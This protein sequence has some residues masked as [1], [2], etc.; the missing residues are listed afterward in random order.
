ML[1]VGVIPRSILVILQDD[2]VDIVKAGGTTK[3]CF[4]IF[5]YIFLNIMFDS[6]HNPTSLIVLGIFLK[7]KSSLL[8]VL[9]SC[10]MFY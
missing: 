10:M 5:L 9:V 3:P 6:V 1:D 4:S 2:L 8:L 7:D